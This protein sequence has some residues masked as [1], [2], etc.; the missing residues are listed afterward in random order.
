MPECINRLL[1]K[2]PRNSNEAKS[3]FGYF[4]SRLSDIGPQ[5]VSRIA[6]SRIVPTTGNATA[7]GFPDEKRPADQGGLKYLTPRSCYLGSSSAY[8]EIFDFVDFGS[9]ANVFLLK[10]GAKQEPT[11]LELATL[12]CREPARLLGVQGQERYMSLLRSLADELPQLK[13]DKVLFK[14]M[15]QSKFLLGSMEISSSKDNRKS[16]QSKFSDDLAEQDED[17]P[18]DASIKQ[19]QLEIPSNTVIVSITNSTCCS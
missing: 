14:Q 19:W 3:L 5:M 11:I 2:P 10:C 16:K 13:R 7:N 9:E 8:S 1:A 6:D 18:E 15:R 17:E 4:A 12:A